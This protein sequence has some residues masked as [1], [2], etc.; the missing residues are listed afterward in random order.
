M[1]YA[2]G[3]DGQLNPAVTNVSLTNV[4]PVD[5]GPTFN[6]NA[7]TGSLGA[8]SPAS[9][10]LAPGAQQ[11]FTATYTLSQGD[12]NNAAGVTNGVANTATAKGTK[13]SG[14]TTTS[15]S[16][17]ANATISKTSALTLVKTSSSP[18]LASG[19]NAA[20]TDA[21]DTITY[22]Y[23]VNNTGNVTLFSVVPSDSGPTFNGSAA[24][25]TLSAYS[26]ASATILP[27][28]S[29]VFTAT[30][31]LTQ[32]DIDHAAGVT[33]GVTNS[34]TA[35]GTQPGGATT[36]SNSSTGQTTIPASSSLTLTK[37][38]GVPTVA[39]GTNPTQTGA[40]D[41]ITYTYTVKNTGN[42]TLTGVV[43]ADTGPT[44]NGAA[45]AGTLGAFSP[46]SA[47]LAPGATQVFTAVYT[48][49]QADMNS[50]A[51][52]TNGVSNTATA[53][54]LQPGG[55]TT[56]T[57]PSTAKT[58]IPEASSLALTKAA[59]AP[60]VALG[61]VST[62]TDGGD[63]ITYT[64]TV[65]NTG[66]VTLTNVAPTDVGPSFNGTPGTGSLGA[67]SPA[68]ATLAPG[69]SMPRPIAAGLTGT[70]DSF[71]P[72]GTSIFTIAMSRFESEAITW[73]GTRVLLSARRTMTFPSPSI[74]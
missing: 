28:A 8:F 2:F 55:A 42:V 4:T 72:A 24:G 1:S 17:T 44:F 20:I 39:L 56:T 31:T 22:S 10:S 63:K 61:T 23:T 32:T 54:G 21:G 19:A 7:G 29:Q 41:T 73:P 49:A 37:A 9:A 47:T 27:G 46:A 43:P 13:P 6:G 58:T 48:L 12:V 40:S 14:A 69:A 34:A 50:A 57:A 53:S 18:S 67:F 60:S 25:A 38:A 36:V 59:G 74:T 70:V 65:R 26:P 64:Y 45:K 68:S 30:Y 62:L 66:N 33:N 11:I 15:P 16:S 3:T 71:I 5:S 35:S 51:G 52:I